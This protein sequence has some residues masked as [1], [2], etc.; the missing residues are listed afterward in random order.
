MLQQKVH[1]AG[2]LRT[3]V[4]NLTAHPKCG[5][6]LQSPQGGS[7]GPRC[8]AVTPPPELEYGVTVS[9]A[10]MSV[11]NE[12]HKGICPVP[13]TH[14]V[15]ISLSLPTPQFPCKLRRLGVSSKANFGVCPTEIGD[16][17]ST[18]G[19]ITCLIWVFTGDS[20]CNDVASGEGR[21]G[22]GLKRNRCHPPW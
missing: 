3:W 4:L 1:G 6:G 19:P 22:R 10:D 21:A 13:G 16:G 15:S 12:V 18:A 2:K 11:S 20:G 8:E 5:H 14:Y 17:R 7:A 9:R